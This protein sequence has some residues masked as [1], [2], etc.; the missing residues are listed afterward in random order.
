MSSSGRGRLINQSLFDIDAVRKNT[1]VPNSGL[2][3]IADDYFFG[4]SVATVNPNWPLMNT[5]VSF[6]AD[7]FNQAPYGTGAF[8]AFKDISD[9]IQGVNTSL[10]RQYE[11][12]VITSTEG[13]LIVLDK[14][15]AFN[16]S[17]PVG[18]Y[19][20]NV[21][22]YRPIFDGAMWPPVASGMAVNLF[23]TTYG[24]DPTL[25]TYTVG[26]TPSWVVAY[27]NAPSNTAPTIVLVSG[28]NYL[29]LNLS[30]GPSQQ[31]VDIV[32]PCLP[33]RQYTTSIMASAGS[34]VDIGIQLADA[35]ASGTTA[36][37]LTS[38][39]L[40]VTFTATSPL[41]AI[42]IGTTGT[43]V[44]TTLSLWNI[45]H[46]T[47]GV[48]HA[49]IATGP[50]IYGLFFGYVERWPASWNYHGIYGM[51]NI[52]VVD[53]LS[54]ISQ[55]N[56]QTAYIQAVLATVPD[57]YWKL[58]ESGTV[59]AFGQ[60]GFAAN[61][62]QLSY[63]YSKSGPGTAL[64]LGSAN[65]IKGDASGAGI[66]FPG[67]ASGA[68][69]AVGFGS[70]VGGLP[71][72]SAGPSIPPS[73][74]P[75]F[76]VT[77]AV[78]LSQPVGAVNG[79]DLVTLRGGVSGGSEVI[80]LQINPGGAVAGSQLLYRSG[81]GTPLTGVTGPGTSDGK[82]HL[83][84]CQ[85]FQDS[86][87]LVLSLYVDGSLYATSTIALSLIGGP[88]AT[89][90]SSI[91]VGA[92][93]IT[94][95]DSQTNGIVSHIAVWNR[96]LSASEVSGLWQ[97]GGLGFSG[98]RTDQRI[99]RLLGYQPFVSTNLEIGATTVGASTITS[100]TAL[101]DA[102]Q[103]MSTS[104]NGNFFG[105]GFGTLTFQSRRHRNLET[106]STRTFGEN[107]AGGEIPYSD[108]ITFDFDPTQIYN[109]VEVNQVNGATAIAKNLASQATYGIKTLTISSNTISTLE[110]VDYATNV[111][112]GHADPVQRVESITINPAANPALWPIALGLKFSDRVTVIRRTPVFIMSSDYFV[113]RIERSRDETGVFTVT[114]QMSPAALNRQPWILGDSVF[115]IL[116]STTVLGF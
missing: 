88:L 85:S 83:F 59:T 67:T 72:T 50:V 16:P 78:W 51:A 61:G 109:S 46:E 68:M 103:Q 105:D 41:Q 18:P 66:S 23:N 19:Y 6:G 14:D 35:T 31:F 9:R 102:I 84:V 1:T 32:V 56:I 39:T 111:V 112:N 115:G 12:D 89:S 40:V 96:A 87:N 25:N 53:A 73:L 45:Q 30:T 29:T 13:T 74:T 27:G 36:V 42:K 71:R 69:T 82:A 99:A 49:F 22:V 38:A 107:S 94:D 116:D 70:Y 81:S 62:P 24:V 93:G 20:P 65:G 92:E 8:P 47:G 97:A 113:E 86:T 28:Q 26:S 60:S 104:E 101:L 55:Q 90:A 33:G 80:R 100:G 76:T 21:K 43:L 34:P 44:S 10:G 114:Y 17:N 98:D 63:I 58:N 95:L 108:D 77:M 37:G 15:E 2:A 52:T 7:P 57:Y 106:A 64:T 48:A 3:A 75:P 91:L 54:I 4:Q 11:L 110:I 5:S 79:T